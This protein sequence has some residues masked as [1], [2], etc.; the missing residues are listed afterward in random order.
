V[1]P[2]AFQGASQL[3]RLPAAQASP[4]QLRQEAGSRAWAVLAEAV[5]PRRAEQEQLEL[6]KVAQLAVP[7]ERPAWQ[8][9]PA[10]V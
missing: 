2:P 1:T 9:E 3:G 6:Q 10:E 5:R 4:P 8:R 7:P